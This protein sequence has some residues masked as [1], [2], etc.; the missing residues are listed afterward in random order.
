MR[1]TYKKLPKTDQREKHIL[2][3][4]MKKMKI[5][6]RYFIAAIWFVNGVLCKILNLVPRHQAIVERIT[7][8]THGRLITLIIGVGEFC[9]SIWVA[10]GVWPKLNAV[11]QILIIILY[12]ILGYMMAPD[13]LLFGS[14]SYIINLTFII[15]IYYNG[16]IANPT[17]EKTNSLSN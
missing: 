6:I 9:I 17:S 8:T 15:L 10:Q 1:N 7:D 4:K 5:F 2:S 3:P 12:S 11:V 16:F 14:F 13:L